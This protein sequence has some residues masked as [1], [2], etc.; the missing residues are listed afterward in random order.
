MVGGVEL[1]PEIEHE[2]LLARRVDVVT[3]LSERRLGDRHPEERERT[4]RVHDDLRA[5]E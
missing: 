5:V 4:G 3:P 2:V 1:A